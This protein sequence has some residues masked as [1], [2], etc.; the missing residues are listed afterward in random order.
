MRDK[1]RIGLMFSCVL[2]CLLVAS[3]AWANGNEVEQLRADVRK[4]QLKLDALED[5][6]DESGQD[7]LKIS[8][9]MDPT[10]IASSNRRS[11]GFNFLNN[12]DAVD[13]GAAGQD[14]DYAFDNSFFG[15][16]M[17]EFKKEM[18]NG[19]RW[20][21]QLV[22][23][24][25][26]SST[27]NI[28]SIVHEATVSIPLKAEGTRIVA[29]QFADF[30]GYEYF[31]AHQTKL[32]T[33]NLLFDFTQASYYAGAG[34]DL[35]H[36]S[37]TTKIL[38]ANMNRASHRERD[39]NPVIVFRTDFANDEFSGVGVTGQFGKY[40]DQRIGMLSTDVFFMRGD[41]ALN[42]QINVGRWKN[43][44][45]NG[46][47]AQ[48]AGVSLQGAFKL[49]PRLEL[50]ARADYLKNDK[51]GGG[52]IGTVFAGCADAFGEAVGCTDP[53][54]INPGAG[55]AR[56][57]FG[58]TPDALAAALSRGTPGMVQGANR[59]ALT[60]GGNYT[61]KDNAV[62]KFEVRYDRADQAAFLAESTGAYR[63]HNTLA[64]TS[65]VVT[66]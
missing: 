61:I 49:T 11:A 37:W 62:L 13:R 59:A 56:N 55:D 16:A 64:A 19:T 38:L 65:L 53:A 18:Q 28:G 26:S 5:A 30:T 60:L 22:P 4:L 47:D 42:G 1:K 24:K 39:R 36:G 7:G 20:H 21:L 50:V 66:F 33:H 35:E 8:G 15:M 14:S 9:M 40:F 10:Y 6:R 23:H 46:G 32:V 31:L 52:T 43:M 57:G 63:K 29:G 58:P 54:V 2:P 34:V 27:F 17:L 48:W 44:A 12:F 45:F 41:W 51:N 25:G 3:P